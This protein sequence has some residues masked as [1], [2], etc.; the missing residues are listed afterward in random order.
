M[1]IK[2]KITSFSLCTLIL[3][4]STMS[5]Y[6][7]FSSY[8][9]N[10]TQNSSIISILIGFIIALFI[11]TLIFKFININKDLTYSKSIK[12]LFPKAGKLLNIISI[13][14]SLFAYILI[15]YRLNTFLSNNYLINTP[16]YLLS[17]LIL[18]LT[19]Y[20]S[21]KGAY[22]IVRLSYITFFITIINVLFDAIN[23]IPQININ[24]YL[25]LIDTNTKQILISSLVFSIY[26]SVPIIY[27]NI[28]PINTCID[29]NKLKRNYYLVISFSFSIIII[30][31]ITCIGVSSSKLLGLFDYPIY[32]SLKRIR[33]FNTID[34]LEN[35]S[36]SSWFLF[37]INT[38]SI[39]LYHIFNTSKLQQK[40]DL[41]LKK[42]LIRN[43][44]L[45][46]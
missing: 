37:I 7:I 44:L 17:I 36:I 20:V 5:F 45:L 46:N 31:I 39:M 9:I 2:E 12:K 35:I 6:G 28:L 34:S 15:T 13:I 3:S 22:T 8:L 14:F 25:P 21:L 18:L 40:Q 16:K 24:N 1:N 42:H 27:I 38:S 10:K 32:S 43:Q 19:Y 23:L 29:I 26:F 41:L 4:L 33:L 30:S 11:S